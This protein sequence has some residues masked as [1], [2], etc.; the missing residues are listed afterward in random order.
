V[1]LLLGEGDDRETVWKVRDWIKG[2]IGQT[3]AKI[4]GRHVL[5]TVEQPSW[6]KNSNSLLGRVAGVFLEV[7]KKPELKIHKDR[8]ARAARSQ[9]PTS[10]RLGRAQLGALSWAW[11]KRAR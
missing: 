7:A 5:V 11:C 8:N 9:S 6:K 3:G 1:P 2:R 4:H 10:T